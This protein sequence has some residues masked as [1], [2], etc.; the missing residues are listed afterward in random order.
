MLNVWVYNPALSHG[1]IS[2]QQDL[3]GGGGERWSSIPSGTPPTLADSHGQNGYIAL[4][5]IQIFLMAREFRGKKI[6]D[7]A[8]TR[9]SEYLETETEKDLKKINN[10]AEQKQS[11]VQT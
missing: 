2:Q 5:L 3:Q 7:C 4:C 11:F 10:R 8:N 6:E 1:Q 9:A